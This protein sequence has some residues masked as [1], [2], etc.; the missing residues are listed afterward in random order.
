MSKK[1]VS[2]T[3][4]AVMEGMTAGGNAVIESFPPYE[5]EVEITG[6]SDLL[7][8]RFNEEEYTTKSEAKKGSK[9]KKLDIPENRIYRDMDGNVCLPGLYLCN[10]IVAAAK[11][12]QDPRSPRKSAMDLYKAGVFA[13]TDLCPIVS[14]TGETC[15]EGWDYL[16]KRGACIQRARIVRVRPAFFKGW[17]A[18]VRLAV[19]LPEYIEPNEL[20]EIITYAGRFCGVGDFRPSYGRFQVTRYEVVSE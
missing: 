2:E 6:V 3:G 10:S 15:K 12:R 9:E 1:I 4:I 14:V 19:Q 7:F 13:S 16:D 8:N 20:H 18:R 11:F 5:V 17:K